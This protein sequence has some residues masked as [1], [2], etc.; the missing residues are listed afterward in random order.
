MC[1]CHDVLVFSVIQ[2]T[3]VTTRKAGVVTRSPRK[4]ILPGWTHSG[5]FDLRGRTSANKP[6]GEVDFFA[7]A[8]YSVK[9]SGLLSLSI[10]KNKIQ[11]SLPKLPH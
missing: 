8:P 3:A 9:S 7:L 5:R 6:S 1:S 10:K 4:L 2:D 11:R